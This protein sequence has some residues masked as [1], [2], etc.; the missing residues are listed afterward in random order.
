MLTKKEEKLIRKYELMSQL[1]LPTM[2]LALAT[3]FVWLVLCVI[4]NFVFHTK[5]T[6]MTGMYVMLGVV[7]FYIVVFAYSV[8]RVQC[9]MRSRKWK[10]IVDKSMAQYIQGDHTAEIGVALGTRAIGNLMA[11]SS[12][13]VAQNLGKGAQIASTMIT[14]DVVDNITDEQQDNVDSVLKANNMKPHKRSVLKTA[15]MWVPLV[16]LLVAYIPIFASANEYSKEQIRVCSKTLDELEKSLSEVC[17]YVS[18]DDPKEYFD[19]DGYSVTGYIRESGEKYNSRI[20]V[21]IDGEGIVKEVSYW[22]NVDDSMSKTDNIEY[23]TADM[24]TLYT[25]LKT[26]NPEVASDVFINTDKIPSVLEDAYTS[27]LSEEKIHEN[28]DVEDNIKLTYGY[29]PVDEYNDTAY[30]Y[31]V[32]E[33]EK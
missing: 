28:Q 2:L 19:T 16:F 18:A 27:L 26:A 12:N 22:F 7:I 10:T 24:L 15:I 8:L 1:G 6:N 29:A 14:V 25:G 5:N 17:E 13:K 33:T 32:L 4:E 23:V 3:P 31:F 11:Q 9:G 20:T 30:L 21:E